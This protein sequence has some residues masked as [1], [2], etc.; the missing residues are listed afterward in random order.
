[1]FSIF[2]S[3]SFME[4]VIIYIIAGVVALIGSQW[5]KQQ[6]RNAEQDYQRQRQKDAAPTPTAPAPGTAAYDAKRRYEDIQEEI[7][8][9]IAQRANVPMPSPTSTV[10][11]TQPRP[12]QPTMVPYEPRDD[13]R[14]RATPPP[15]ARPQPVAPP[16]PA[17]VSP[18]AMTM[19]RV[20][21]PMADTW[22][23]NAPAY[24]D[25]AS[26]YSLTATQESNSMSALRAALASASSARHAF[27]LRE[28]L[29][30]PLCAR[31]L[32][33]GGHDNWN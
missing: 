23:S 21:T 15:I 24:P 5:K 10:Q 9:R 6:A 3:V 1:L 30:R 32:C 20:P 8:R 19:A 14:P 22:K 28:V 29:D 13:S 17:T 27:I 26:A 16:P 33:S 12:V 7:R 25:E 31:P 18:P 2:H 11:P 4:Q